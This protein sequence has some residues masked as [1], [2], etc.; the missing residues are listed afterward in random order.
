MGNLKVSKTNRD[1]ASLWR[2]LQRDPAWRKVVEELE[3]KVK[4]AD[5]VINMIGGD[6]DKRYSQ[7]DIAIV[8]KN[9]Y[10]DLIEMP[11]NNI[12]LLEGTGVEEPEELDPFEELSDD[13]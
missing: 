11:Q 9:S 10:L 7:R 12:E 6:G 2:N 3:Q 13:L 8:K 1:E 4:E 5:T